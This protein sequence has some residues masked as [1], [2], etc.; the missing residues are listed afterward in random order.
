M[1]KSTI[2]V[3]ISAYNEEKKIK[4]CLES[5]HKFADEIIFVDNNSTD[6][7]TEIAK[8]YTN[9]IFT[10]KNDPQNIDLQKNLGIQ[11]AT[12]D[13]ILVLD[14]DEIVSVELAEEIKETINSQ[15]TTPFT[16]G[17]QGDLKAN[18]DP[19]SGYQIP[20]KNIIFNKWIQHS[21]WYPDYQLRLFK[22]GK[23][24]YEK[25]HVHEPISVLG[26]TGKLTH[27]LI[28]HNYETISQFLYKHLQI[29]APNEAADLLSKG[30]KFDWKGIIRRPMSEFLSRYFAR[31]GYKDGFH[32]LALALLMAFYHL[33]IFMYIWEKQK[34]TEIKHE[35]IFNGLEDEIK[36]SK[37][38]LNY[39][40]TH[41]KIESE[42][43][44]VKKLS[45]KIKNKLNIK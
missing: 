23:G 37:R 12:K 9:K 31:E 21:G 5:V 18:E 7:T 41:Y 16:K 42:K 30:Y 33:T 13:W 27:P 6:K 24:K 22:N 2:S 3:V 32:G 28:H 40:L 45:I 44:L 29:Y 19:I 17:G 35:N 39:W 11:K 14:A 36:K 8:K 38:E 43:N 20:R 26:N 25:K 4:N 34:F 10:Q 1:N 15:S